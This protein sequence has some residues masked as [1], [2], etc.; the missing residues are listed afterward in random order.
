MAVLP[1]G[2]GIVLVEINSVLVGVFT[3]MLSRF[4]FSLSIYAGVGLGVAVFAV[5][6]LM[7]HRHQVNKFADVGSRMETLFPCDSK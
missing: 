7:H 5:S 3:G 6:V 2:S 1:D 4:A